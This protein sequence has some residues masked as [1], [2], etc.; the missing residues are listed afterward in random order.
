MQG[1]AV[2]RPRR[3]QVAGESGFTLIELM[4]VVAIIGILASI[5]VPLYRH[6]ETRAKVSEGLIL[7][8]PL[9]QA[10]AEYYSTHGHL[11]KSNSWNGVLAELNMP[12]GNDGAASGRY[13]Q[14]IW[15]HN[16]PD[17]PGIYIKYSGG[18]IQDRVVYLNA[19]FGSGAIRWDCT[20][21][22]EDDSTNPGVPADDLPA[23]CR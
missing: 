13:V 17:A 5:A 23:S 15:W 11:P 3:S 21:P 22:A 18:S 20:A 16:D 12:S 4:I 14:R 1:G 10:V 7:A 6:Y 19:D 9:K 8:Q 2:E